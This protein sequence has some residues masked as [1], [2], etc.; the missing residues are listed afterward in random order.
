MGMQ[1]W[2]ER[3]FV[4]ENFL[5]FG[6]FIEK[7]TIYYK[8][9]VLYSY[10]TPPTPPPPPILFRVCS[11]THSS[12]IFWDISHIPEDTFPAKKNNVHNFIKIG[13]KK[14]ESVHLKQVFA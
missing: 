13:S 14:T 7:I 2:N 9:S 6:I 10:P 4:P 12:L 11:G 8:N 1:N 3:H 5:I